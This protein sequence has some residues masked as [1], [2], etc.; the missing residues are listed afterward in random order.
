MTDK[1][2]E[3]AL[4]NLLFSYWKDYIIAGMIENLSEQSIDPEIIYLKMETIGH[5]TGLSIVEKYLSFI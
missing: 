3:E 2:S 4:S 5:R 1:V